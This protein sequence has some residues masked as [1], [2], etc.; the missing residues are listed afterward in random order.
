M[1]ELE[2]DAGTRA[3]RRTP[4]PDAGRPLR[5]FAPP[6]PPP[7]NEHCRRF[8]DA[9]IADEDARAGDEAETI[10]A[11]RVAEAASIRAVRIVCLVL[12]VEDSPNV[13]QELSRLGASI[14]KALE[15]SLDLRRGLRGKGHVRT[16][17]LDDLL[18]LENLEAEPYAIAADPPGTSDDASHRELLPHVGRPRTTEATVADETEDHPARQ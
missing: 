4:E 2:P 18:F 10:P 15:D 7:P 16:D 6:A 3:R 5:Q 1:P 8:R 13:P 9:A 12:P 11:R 14:A 17:L